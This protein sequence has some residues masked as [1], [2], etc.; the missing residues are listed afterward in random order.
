MPELLTKNQI[1]V[2]NSSINYKVVNFLGEGGQG[3]VY[4]ATS[5]HG[6]FAIKWYNDKSA[7]SE[8]FQALIKIISFGPPA[9]NF[10]WPIEVIRMDG[11]KNYGYV[12][13][14]REK[15][16]KGLIDLMN[17]KINPSFN[18]LII[19]SCKLVDR[20]LQLHTKGLCYRDI[21]FGNVFFDP[22]NGEVLICD[23]DNVTVDNQ[24]KTHFIYGTPKFMAPEIVR[25]E[26]LPNGDTDRFSLA[27]LL[28][29]MF[30]VSHPLDG[31]NETKIHC[32]DQAAMKKL[33]GDNPI[34]IFDPNNDT[35]RPDPN[36]HKNALLYWELY[37]KF[38]KDIFVK[39]FTDGIHDP[40]NGRVRET[41]WRYALLKLKN[42]LIYCQNCGSE[43]FYDENHKSPIICWNCK[44]NVKIP[45]ILQIGSLKIM[46]NYN[47]IIYKHHLDH[48][49]YDFKEKIAKLSP[50]PRDNSVWG[51]TNI[52]NRNWKVLRKDG[53]ESTIEPNQTVAILLGQIIDFGIAKGEIINPINHRQ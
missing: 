17:G 24:Y 14:L 49:S 5:N 23:C 16:F 4:R 3:E 15:R 28:F 7:T 6:E 45:P 51:L 30:V 42:S 10:L 48:V 18:N 35:N 38:F 8:Q 1:L 13:P 26:G 36:I 25:G 40:I 21:N 32:F 12:M 44:K 33:Y 19:A 37:P 43:N 2:S 52:S 22:N 41:E 27:V 53:K 34:F 46:L 11:V 39:A 9:G 50:N 20:F 47:T 29:Y 31:K